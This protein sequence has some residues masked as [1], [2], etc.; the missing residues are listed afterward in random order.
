MGGIFGGPK[1]PPA[2]PPPPPLPPVTPLADPEDERLKALR[3]RGAAAVKRSGRLS[4]QLSDA[5]NRG[6]LG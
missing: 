2:P 5:G 1:A 6:T 3:K 4:T